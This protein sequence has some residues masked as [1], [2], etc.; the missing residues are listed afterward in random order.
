MLPEQFNMFYALQVTS[1]DQN[2]VHGFVKAHRKLEISDW[3]NLWKW[4][5][6]WR[7]NPREWLTCTQSGSTLEDPPISFEEWQLH[8]GSAETG[9]RLNISSPDL[10]EGSISEEMGGECTTEVK[11]PLWVE[12][13]AP[14]KGHRVDRGGNAGEGTRRWKLRGSLSSLCQLAWSFLPY[15]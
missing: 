2:S 3:R 5:S 1:K 9:D 13:A 4:Y 12:L 15:E 11:R 10:V 14:E 7:L 8:S 6:F